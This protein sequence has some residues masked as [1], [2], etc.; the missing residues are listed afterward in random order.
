MIQDTELKCFTCCV[1]QP[2]NTRPC[3][4]PYFCSSIFPQVSSVHS[5]IEVYFIV[6]AVQLYGA[7]ETQELLLIIKKPGHPKPGQQTRV[8][9]KFPWRS[10]VSLFPGLISSQRPGE[11]QMSCCRKG[12]C[13]IRAPLWFPHTF[14]CWPRL[15]A[16]IAP[17]CRAAGGLVL[18]KGRRCRSERRPASAAVTAHL[19][20]VV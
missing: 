3:T 15:R 13:S 20:T 1:L 9:W 17:R 6:P 14:G 12:L 7:I 5:G 8:L 19:T 11:S 10:Q 2:I 16:A 4:P 18:E